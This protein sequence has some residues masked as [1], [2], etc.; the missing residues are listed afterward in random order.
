MLLVGCAG[1]K[2]RRG[3][4]YHAKRLTYKTLKKISPSL[5][6][7]KIGLFA[8]RDYLNLSPLM[9]ESFKKIVNENLE[10][11]AEKITAPCLIVFGEND[12]ETPLYMARKLNAKIKD[13]ELIVLK[14]CSHFCFVERAIEFNE[15]AKEFFI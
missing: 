12:R 9:R 8:S 6:E 7:K 5:A 3:V 2:P 1:M 15:I 4:R 14:N 13:S 10:E 11:C